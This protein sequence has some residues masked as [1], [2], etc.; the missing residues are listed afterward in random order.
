LNNDVATLLGYLSDEPKQLL[1]LKS[2][3]PFATEVSFGLCEFSANRLIE[4]DRFSEQRAYASVPDTLPETPLT[5]MV[6]LPL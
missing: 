5:E 3:P 2:G 4:P 1:A 6:E